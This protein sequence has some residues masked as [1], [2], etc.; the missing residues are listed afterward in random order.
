MKA[1]SE[2]GSK[3]PVVNELHLNNNRPFFS[4][5]I[6]QILQEMKNPSL[7][8]FFTLITAA[9]YAQADRFYYPDAFYFVKEVNVASQK[10]K[11]FHFDISVKENPADSL[12]RPRIYTIQARKGKED[13]IG[14][15]FAYAKAGNGDWRT[16]SIDGTIDQEASRVWLYVA[17]NGNGDFYFDNLHFFVADSTGA[18]REEKL[19]NTSFEEK[20]LLAGYYQSKHASPELRLRFSPVASDGKQSLQVSVSGQ[21]AALNRNLSASVGITGSF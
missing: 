15:S 3:K 18:L 17:V 6:Y 10:G 14:N 4:F 13:F 12:S 21:K 19:A 1:A 11:A 9:T 20:K 5:S 7:L 2:L 8:L 16:Y